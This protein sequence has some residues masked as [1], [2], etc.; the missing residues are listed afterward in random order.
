MTNEEIHRGLC[1][2]AEL[3]GIKAGRINSNI[4]EVDFHTTMAFGA[5]VPRVI[6]YDGE[7]RP[8][9]FYLYQTKRY[10]NCF[11]RALA[12]WKESLNLDSIRYL[13]L[14][15]ER[16]DRLGEN[17]RLSVELEFYDWW[18]TCVRVHICSSNRG[19][20]LRER[21]FHPDCLA[22]VRKY[23]LEP[24]PQEVLIDVLEEYVEGFGRIYHWGEE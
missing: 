4:P 3:I 21:C 14:E 22:A 7:C 8:E 18:K 13:K 1:E 15:Q 10:Y 24:Y 20:W 11:R 23:F 12:E 16:V 17:A 5:S 6:E 19:D 2:A 9:W